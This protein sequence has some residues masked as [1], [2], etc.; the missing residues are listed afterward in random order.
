MYN[1]YLK[2]VVVERS[3]IEGVSNK[4]SALRW[5]QRYKQ[6]RAKYKFDFS[7]TEFIIKDE[8]GVFVPQIVT[9]D[10]IR[11]CLPWLRMVNWTACVCTFRILKYNTVPGGVMRKSSTNIARAITADLRVKAEYLPVATC[12][13]LPV[14]TAESRLLSPKHTWP[15]TMWFTARASVIAVRWLRLCKSRL[16]PVE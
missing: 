11:W 1:K 8:F 14:E 2:N 3:L 5:L 4:P 16:Q 15:S 12:H 13:Q 7:D 9:R 10:F 6:R